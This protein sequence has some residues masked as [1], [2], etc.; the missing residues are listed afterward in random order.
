MADTQ[1]TAKCQTCLDRGLEPNEA[2]YSWQGLPICD[3]CLGPLMDN[4]N[5]IP[6]NAPVTLGEHT[7]D[8]RKKIAAALLDQLEGLMDNWPLTKEETQKCHEDFYNHRPPA[9]VNLSLSQAQA[10][11]SR[12]KGILFA[13]RHKDERWA[14]DI[15]NLKREQREAANLVGIAASKKETGKRVV[16]ESVQRE[17]NAKVAASIGLTLEQYEATL[18]AARVARFEMVVENPGVTKNIPFV[19]TTKT[20]EI[21]EDLKAKIKERQVASKPKINPVTGRPYA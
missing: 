4:V 18:S 15:E 19:Q 11:F 12:R 20:G 17:K 3:A 5:D 6:L 16:S 9:I 8:D 10:I 13:V 7:L 2:I 21:L 14:T 1:V